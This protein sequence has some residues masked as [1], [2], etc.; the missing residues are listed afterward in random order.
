MTN[1]ESEDE[2]RNRALF[3]AKKKAEGLVKQEEKIEKEKEW[4]PC[5]RKI[6]SQFFFNFM[7]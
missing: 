6:L 4:I 3:L 7:Q 5:F 1:K 2:V